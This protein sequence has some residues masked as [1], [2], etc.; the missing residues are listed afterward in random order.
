MN[1]ILNADFLCAPSKIRQRVL[2][3]MQSMASN[4]VLR[5]TESLFWR[6]EELGQH[7]VV[8]AFRQLGWSPTVGQ[9]ITTNELMWGLSIKERYRKL[10]EHL[11]P[12]VAQRIDDQWHIFHSFECDSNTLREALERQY[13]HAVAE[14]TI[15]DRCASQ[16]PDVLIGKLDPLILLFPAEGDVGAEQLYRDSPLARIVNRLLGETVK[17]A[18]GTLPDNRTLRVLEV[19]AGTGGA[20]GAIL[21]VFPGDK[22]QYSFTDVSAAFFEKS[23]LRFRD[24]GFVSYGILDI[25][26][27]PQSQGFA[28]CNFDLIIAANVLHATSDLIQTLNYLRWLLA[29]KGLLI[30]QE[31]TRQ[32]AWLDLTFGLLPGWW[33]FQDSVRTNY[34]LIKP[35]QWFNL[36]SS[37]GFTEINTLVPHGV[38]NQAIVISQAPAM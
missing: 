16:L 4:K 2:D 5:N 14:I 20:T 25:E 36:L 10:I 23:S 21:P 34:P 9:C 28:R 38:S 33:K 8:R 29:P 37:Q 22:T 3:E 19:G 7:Y 26:K 6:M 15:L 31:M 32:Q 35:K 11:L 17:A 13:P 1:N 30:F 18:I 12:M 24:Y 27:D